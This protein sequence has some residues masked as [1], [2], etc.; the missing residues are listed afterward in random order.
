MTEELPA[1]PAPPPKRR[2]LDVRRILLSLLVVGALGLIAFGFASGETGDPTRTITDPAIETVYPLPNSPVV[3]PQTQIY[4]DLAPGFR[5]EL[6]LDG[7]LLSTQDLQPA[8]GQPGETI[9]A[10]TLPAGAADVTFDSALN[11]LTFTPRAGTSVDDRLVDGKLASGQHVVTVTYWPIAE[12]P[13]S[14]RAFS[15]RFNVNA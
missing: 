6:K 15:W 5:G 14:A 9:P 10:V 7:Q 2:G 13:G 12:G 8:A 3:P 4:V 1:A 11:T